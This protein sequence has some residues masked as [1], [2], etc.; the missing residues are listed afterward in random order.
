MSGHLD[1]GFLA[2]SRLFKTQFQIVAEVC[3]TVGRT[4]AT[5]ARPAEHV[6]KPK[7]ISENVTEI[8][9]NARVE[10]AGTRP[11]SAPD[12]RMSETIVSP[13]FLRI[14]Q[15]GIGFSRLFELLFRLLVSRAFC[16]DGVP[17]PV[18]GRRS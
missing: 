16:P 18:F 15:Y 13:T 3:T 14:A 8:G 10:S 5:P 11:S 17:A 12:T 6:A 2:E 7:K 1:S 4:A 9:K